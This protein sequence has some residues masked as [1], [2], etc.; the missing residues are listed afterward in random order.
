MSEG[1]LLLKREIF[2]SHTVQIGSYTFCFLR[3]KIKPKEK[4]SFFSDRVLV[5]VL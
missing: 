4:K 1:C 3:I 5:G 2:T